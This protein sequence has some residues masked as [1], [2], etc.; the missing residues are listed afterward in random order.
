MPHPSLPLRSILLSATTLT[1]PTRQY[2]TAA[3]AS[4]TFT[5]P[6]TIQRHP[7][8]QPPSHKNPAFR[9]SQL[10]RQYA[11]LLTTTPLLLILQHNNL[12]AAEWAGIRRELT[13]A[14]RRAGA[15]DAAVAAA[16]LQIIQTGIFAAALRVTEATRGAPAGSDGLAHVLSREAH[17]AAA[18]ATLSRHARTLEGMLAGPLAVLAFPAVT[19]AQLGAALRV[20]APTPGAASAF[21]APRRR[22][23]PG[24]Y[25]GAVQ[26]GLAKLMLLGA[27]VEGRVMDGEGTRWVGGITGGIDGLRGQLVNLLMG[28]GMGVTSALDAQ[29]RSLYITMEGRRLAMEEEVNPKTAEAPAASP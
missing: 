24:Y 22:D 6:T 15:D 19:P 4:A 20:L 26:S 27:R 9:K 12:R 18:R 25:D 17:T 3:A 1:T 8:T 2:A 21:A 29:A 10:L 5:S 23:A 7:T 11:S 14:L 16:K 13:A 28:A